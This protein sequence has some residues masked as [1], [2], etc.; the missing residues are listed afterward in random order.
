MDFSNLLLNICFGEMIFRKFAKENNIFLQLVQGMQE[1]K[2]NNAD[3]LKRW[4]W[5]NV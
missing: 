1:L 3:N 5:E 2:L 4:E